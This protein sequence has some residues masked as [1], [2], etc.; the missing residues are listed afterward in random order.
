MQILLTSSSESFEV[1]SIG[2]R[3]GNESPFLG[4][5]AHALCR[6]RQNLHRQGSH[7]L[8]PK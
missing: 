4:E 1:F 7:P 3:A 6:Q 5:E 2:I 8:L